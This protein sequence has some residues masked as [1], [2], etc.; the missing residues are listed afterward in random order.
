MCGQKEM[1]CFYDDFLLIYSANL[2]I[3]MEAKIGFGSSPPSYVPPPAPPPAAAPPTLAS[4]SVA[5]SAA[6]RQNT[7][8]G[9]Q[10]SFGT[11]GGAEGVAPTSVNRA[12]TTLGGVS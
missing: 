2:I 7:I 9:E 4:S 11:S 3:P 8:K 12:A 1:V 6:N 5:A 10:A